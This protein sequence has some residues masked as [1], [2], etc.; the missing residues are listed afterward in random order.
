MCRRR[1]RGS[2]WSDCRGA[3]ERPRAAPVRRRLPT[4]RNPPP[5][6]HSRH[7]NTPIRSFYSPASSVS[8]FTTFFFLLRRCSS[9]YVD[10]GLKFKDTN[11]RHKRQ[12]VVRQARA[13]PRRV[14]KQRVAPR[15][16]GGW[17]WRPWG[18][19]RR[20]V[21]RRGAGPRP[22]PPPRPHRARRSHPRRPPPRCA[23]SRSRAPRYRA[24]R[25]APPCSRARAEL[26]ACVQEAAARQ[27]AA[28]RQLPEGR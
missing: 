17:C 3:A 26:I 23:S 19:R 22:R 18:A 7:P 28:A 16:C 4:R 14:P 24:A 5:H 21:R 13:I 11:D 10:V 27:P 8:S 15:C 6:S 20:G 12:S 2:S 1:P 25:R 9:V